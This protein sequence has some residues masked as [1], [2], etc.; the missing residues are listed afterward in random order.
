[1]T[2]KRARAARHLLVEKVVELIHAYVFVAGDAL[3][4]HVD[5]FQGRVDAHV[6]GDEHLLQLV[7]KVLVDLAAAH[8]C[9]FHLLEEA[10]FGLL[11]ALVESLFLLF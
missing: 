10:G 1:M 6:G 3:L 8:G 7:E 4:E 11:E 2:A 5:D 9:A